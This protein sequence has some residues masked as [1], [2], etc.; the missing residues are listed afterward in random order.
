MTN[1]ERLEDVG[2]RLV[3]LAAERTL[4][5]WLRLSLALMSLGFVLDRFGLFIRSRGA[6]ARHTWLPR[7]YTFWMG[8]GL[9]VAGALTAIAAGVAYGWFR[10]RYKRQ[11]YGGPAGTASLSLVLSA[12][13]TAI[14]VVTAIFLS[15]ITD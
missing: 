1:D 6:G 12:L 15:T 10:L 13:I 7:S 9:V 3:I 14:G 11:G 2:P 8:T 4:L 5:G